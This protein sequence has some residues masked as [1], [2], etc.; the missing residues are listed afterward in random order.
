MSLLLFGP[1]A[2]ICLA[3]GAAC[4][5]LLLRDQRFQRT[6]SG[7][8]ADPGLEPPTSH[9]DEAPLDATPE[10]LVGRLAETL[11][12]D[13]ET[14]LG[15][16]AA[17]GE[18]EPASAVLRTGEALALGLP[19]RVPAAVLVQLD[20][21]KLVGAGELA[22]GLIPGLPAAPAGVDTAA[23]E[24]E[25]QAAEKAA[26]ALS[27]NPFE[28][29]EP[30]GDRRWPVAPRDGAPAPPDDG[31]IAARVAAVPWRGS[32]GWHGLVVTRGD[33]PEASGA[34]FSALHARMSNLGERLGLAFELERRAPAAPAGGEPPAAG[35]AATSQLG[36][37][38][39]PLPTFRA[40]TSTLIAAERRVAELLIAPRSEADILR[41]TI[42]LLADGLQ[43]DRC[44]AV[45]VAGLRPRPVEHERRC[46]PIASAVGLDLGQGFVDAVR[47]YA[48]DDFG[49]VVIDSRTSVSLMPEPASRHLSPAAQLAVP[50][51]EKGGITV[52]FVAERVGEGAEDWSGDDIAFAE[53]VVARASTAREQL[54]R[55]DSLALQVAHE[56]EE[57][58]QLVEAFEQLQQ[59]MAALPDG[60]LGIDGEGRV[61]FANRAAARLT[62]RSELDL[63]NLWLAELAVEIGGS[64]ETWEVA[65]AATRT[66]RRVAHFK[67]PS[68]VVPVRVT[69]VPL[70]RGGAFSRLIVLTAEE[71]SATRD[72]LVSSRG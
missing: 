37:Q 8:P 14:L 52:V 22:S 43:A 11:D 65:L 2:L 59:V 39:R 20:G 19:E 10:A 54:A 69:V 40:Q 61:T 29:G 31:A 58:D 57:R 36:S 3:A 13:G 70:A 46:Q 1:L 27:D 5:W 42:S 33:S 68:G 56:R 9:S 50:I 4:A 32:F 64:A 71:A 23:L 60:L 34:H 26:G 28:L 66:E 47:S 51:V 15:V 18:G 24:A 45:Q 41:A 25:Q 49:A 21:P 38:P 63:T 67:R 16:Y 35:R 12:R 72:E 30:D 53:H 44:Y 48:R 62:G 6:W 17:R 7:L 55:L